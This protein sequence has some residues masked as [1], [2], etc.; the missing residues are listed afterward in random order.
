MRICGFFP[1]SRQ[2]QSRAASVWVRVY[3]QRASHCYF[4]QKSQ[5]DS[6]SD[7]ASN[8]ARSLAIT[9]WKPFGRFSGFLATMPWALYKLRSGTTNSEM[10][11]RQWRAM[12]VPVGPQQAKMTSSLTKCGIGHAGLSCHRPRTCRG[13][14]DKHWFGPFHFDRWF[15]H[16]ESVAAA[17][18]QCTS[19]F[20]TTDPNFLGQTQHSCGSTGS[21]L[22]QHGCLWFLAL[23]PPENA[24]ET[25]SVWV[26]RRH[27][28]E[29]DG[30]AAH[31]LQEAFQKCFEQCRPTGRSVISHKETTSKGIRVA[32]LQ[33]CKCIFPGQRSDTFW[34]GHVCCLSTCDC[35]L[36][37]CRLSFCAQVI[38]EGD[39]RLISNVHLCMQ[40][41]SLL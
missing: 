35:L 28:T 41:I 20:L 21:L 10:A 7:I 29:H 8:F 6:S 33:A 31:C 30:Q 19:A 18:W 17:S 15:G 25:D 2:R 40:G 38:S 11:T 12:L 14:G 1:F 32:D 13:G 36:R 4:L 16:A 3:T 39:L 27:Y 9:K 23:P 5:N 24:A 37:W 22:S 26:K 34:T